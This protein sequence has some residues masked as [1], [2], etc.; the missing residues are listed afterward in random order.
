MSTEKQ[1]QNSK[2][3]MDLSGLVA[4]GGKKSVA[5]VP[6]IGFTSIGG[7]RVRRSPHFTGSPEP[8]AELTESI[9]KENEHTSRNEA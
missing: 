8:T 9:E 6:E 3:P 5:H 7:K 2:A 4:P 1:N